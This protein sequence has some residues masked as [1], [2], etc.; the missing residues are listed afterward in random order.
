MT[1]SEMNA[2]FLCT[3]CE[4]V[5]GLE[6]RIVMPGYDE[7]TDMLLTS[8]YC[9][10]C[11]PEKMKTTRAYAKTAIDGEPWQ[12]DGGCKYNDVIELGKQREK[13]AERG[14]TH[15]F[16]FVEECS[17]CMR[18]ETEC[19]NQAFDA[20]IGLS[21]PFKCIEC[22]HCVYICPDEVLKVNE[23][24]KDVYSN[25]LENWHLTEEMMDEKRSKIIIKAWQAAF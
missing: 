7:D 5:M 19:P 1:E 22:M 9:K 4:Q 16:R 11:A 21:D 20:E 23:R 10:T 15:P 2:V 13:S 12:E 6:D 8:Y 24:M 18:C 3:G 25:F 14:W 17:M